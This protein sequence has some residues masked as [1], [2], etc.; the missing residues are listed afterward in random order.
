MITTK[1][2]KTTLLGGIHSSSF[3]KTNSARQKKSQCRNSIANLSELRSE[4]VEK[5]MGDLETTSC[6]KL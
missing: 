4:K 6:C 3:S 1:K 2:Q 5:L